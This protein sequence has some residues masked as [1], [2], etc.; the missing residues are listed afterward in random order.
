MLA[1]ADYAADRYAAW[2]RLASA[3]AI[4]L[5]LFAAIQLTQPTWNSQLVVVVLGELSI[6]CGA[7]YLTQIRWFSAAVPWLLSAFDAG[8]LFGVGWFNPW[9]ERLPQGY[10]AALVSPLLAF[11]LIALAAVRPR[12]STIL[13]QTA[14][15][16]VSVALVLWWPLR[17]VG[18]LAPQSESFERLFSDESNLFRLSIVILTGAVLA[19]GAYRS[20]AT[21]MTAIRTA[22]ERTALQRFVPAELDVLLASSEL[23]ALRRGDRHRIVAL[24]MD[25]RGFTQLSEGADPTEVVA[26]LNAFRARAERVMTRHGGVIDKFIGDAILVVFGIVEAEP[27]DAVRC[28]D[29]IDDI[30]AEMRAW[31]A[32]RARDGQDSVRIGIGAHLGDAFVGA[33]GSEHRLEFTVIGDVVDVAQRLEA[34]TRSIP[35]EAIVSEALFTAGRTAG[36][37]PGLWQPLPEA[38]LKGRVS[39]I[40]ILALRSSGYQAR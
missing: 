7:V 37:S 21:L 39:P 5:V 36:S 40:G 24:F 16:A 4:G 6:A 28:L 27:D 13:V 19:A 20:R 9:F 12:A 8:F 29:A 30:V 25:I 23:Q 18:T 11:L 33:L 10:R 34:L 26:L 35:T 2:I 3:T 15:M 32:E 22:R 14:S 1:E 38:T 31:N 17:A